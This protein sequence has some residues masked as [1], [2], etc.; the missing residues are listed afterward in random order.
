MGHQ[1]GP[2]NLSSADAA[3]QPAVS[4][5]QS[6][7]ARSSASSVTCSRRCSTW[8]GRRRVRAGGSPRG[9][10]RP[11]AAARWRGCVGTSA[12]Q[13]SGTSLARSRRSRST[14][15]CAVGLPR[16]EPAEH[17]KVRVLSP[18][19]SPSITH[20]RRPQASTRL[21]PISR[22]TETIHASMSRRVLRLP[23]L[24]AGQGPDVGEASRDAPAQELGDGP[25]AAASPAADACPHAA[26]PA[27]H[28]SSSPWPP[29]TGSRTCHG[30]GGPDPAAPRSSDSHS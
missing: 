24:V 30:H 28:R 10:E 2:L 25:P 18:W 5:A 17:V 11:R 6:A 9:P 21:G 23:S 4:F 15:S 26:A 14:R 12:V 1:Q 20:L 19:G 8:S 3:R 27:P 7:T 16:D 22:F 13:P 29:A